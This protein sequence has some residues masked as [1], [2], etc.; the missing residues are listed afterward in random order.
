MATAVLYRDIMSAWVE[1]AALLLLIT[2]AI[3]PLGR[4]MADVFA[5]ADAGP[6]GSRTA[7]AY[8]VRHMQHRRASRNAMDDVLRRDRR[9]HRG[10]GRGARRATAV[11]APSPSEPAARRHRVRSRG[12]RRASRAGQG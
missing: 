4:Y 5:A 11:A 8:G 9:V 2:A 7:R 10:L 1:F 6:L 12:I 3:P